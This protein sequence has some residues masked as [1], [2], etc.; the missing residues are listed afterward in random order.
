MHKQT[1]AHWRPGLLLS[2]L[3]DPAAFVQYYWRPHE[4]FS[5][6]QCI[7]VC[8]RWGEGWVSSHAVCLKCVSCTSYQAQPGKCSC[9][10]VFLSFCH[11]GSR[12][13][14]WPRR[15]RHLPRETG[16]DGWIGRGGGA[17]KGGIV[18]TRNKLKWVQGWE[19]DD[20]PCCS[21]SIEV[22]RNVGVGG[23]E[24]MRRQWWWGV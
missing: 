2:S 11:G 3:L 5:S 21:V 19:R 24:Q 9:R 1:V 16:V 20:V 17:E 12:H 7:C 18:K 23:E 13:A 15:L 4:W 22:R 14:L 6:E 10:A 8:I